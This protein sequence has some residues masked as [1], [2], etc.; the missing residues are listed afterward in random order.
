M[1]QRYRNQL[2]AAAMSP[3]Q[4]RQMIGKNLQMQVMQHKILNVTSQ[5]GKLLQEETIRPEAGLEVPRVEA[6]RY[7][8]M[9]RKS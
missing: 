1:K 6:K 4:N 7:D 8:E 5:Q 3:N 2:S 9:R